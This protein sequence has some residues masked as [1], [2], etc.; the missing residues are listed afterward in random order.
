MGTSIDPE[1]PD[2]S[3]SVSGNF[4]ALATP[5]ALP[6]EAQLQV[7]LPNHLASEDR[8][9]FGMQVNIMHWYWSSHQ[10]TVDAI[11]EPT[12][13]VK[14]LDAQTRAIIRDAIKGKSYAEA[15]QALNKLK[16]QHVISSYTLPPERDKIPSTDFLLNLEVGEPVPQS[17]EG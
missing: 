13:E 8:F 14:E 15:E 7:A 9:P 17:L 4:S 12:G 6:L 1:H 16:D 11:L 5:P 2:F 3:V 10:L